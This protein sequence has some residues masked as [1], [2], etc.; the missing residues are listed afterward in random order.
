MPFDDATPAERDLLKADK[1]LLAKVEKESSAEAYDKVR[2]V[3]GLPDWR[4]G[5]RRHGR[6]WR[7]GGRWPAPP[8]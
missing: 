7:S 4:R 1:A 3:L 2:A 5:Y 6:R 8:S